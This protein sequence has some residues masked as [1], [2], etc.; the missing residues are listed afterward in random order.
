M[1]P[2]LKFESSKGTTGTYTNVVIV[3]AKMALSIHQRNIMIELRRRDELTNHELSYYN[4]RTLKSLE[5]T[6]FVILDEDSGSWKLT[7]AGRYVANVL[8]RK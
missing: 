5:K 8:S 3:L 7:R 2:V 1:H 4:W 6:N